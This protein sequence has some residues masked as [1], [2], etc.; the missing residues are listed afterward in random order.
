M[1]YKLHQMKIKHSD[2]S[3]RILPSFF[4]TYLITFRCNHGQLMPQTERGRVTFLCALS[5][6]CEWQLAFSGFF[7]DVAY[8]YKALNCEEES[9]DDPMGNYSYLHLDGLNVCDLCLILEIV[10]SGNGISWNQF[11]ID[12]WFMI[13]PECWWVLE[14]L[15][16]FETLYTF[17][18]KNWLNRNVFELFGME[19]LLKVNMDRDKLY[20]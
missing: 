7:S 20:I 17:N 16:L 9:Q 11:V 4:P 14:L 3:W 12:L 18:S 13:E 10:E 19:S 15:M 1:L 8:L 2:L 6:A 5:P